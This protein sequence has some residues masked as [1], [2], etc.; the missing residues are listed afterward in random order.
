MLR[1]RVYLESDW[2]HS[3]STQNHSEP[4]RTT[5]FCSEISVQLRIRVELIGTNWFRSEDMG[6]RKVLQTSIK[7]DYY[8]F[9]VGVPEVLDEVLEHVEV[10][11]N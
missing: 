3:E 1:L 2:N 8:G 7:L 4:L 11:V 9:E 6:H 10:V 5:W